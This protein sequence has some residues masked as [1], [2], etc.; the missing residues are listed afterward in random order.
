MR[1]KGQLYIICSICFLAFKVPCRP[2][3]TYFCVFHLVNYQNTQLNAEVKNQTS[4]RHFFRLLGRFTV[5]AFVG[6]PC[7]LLRPT[8]CERTGFYDFK[9]DVFLYDIRLKSNIKVLSI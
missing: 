9:H 1:L 8:R 6:N 3:L 2:K 4:K 7:I 5:S